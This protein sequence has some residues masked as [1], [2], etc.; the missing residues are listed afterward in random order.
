MW[1]VL[2]ADPGVEYSVDMVIEAAG[3]SPEDNV[4]NRWGSALNALVV[5]GHD[6]GV[7]RLHRGWYL[8]DPSLP[9]EEKKYGPGGS[10]RGTKQ[11]AARK[12]IVSAPDQWREV[13]AEL[14]EETIK[15]LISAADASLLG[16][17]AAGNLIVR[18]T[19]GRI[20]EMRVKLEGHLV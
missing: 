10:A 13:D 8:Y 6:R 4:G 7:R 20:W 19:E 14:D 3:V 16:K 5:G 9:W 2:R 18:D 17:S 11:A 12:N 1:D 15:H